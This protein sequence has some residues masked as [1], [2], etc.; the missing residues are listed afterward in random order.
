MSTACSARIDVEQRG[1][2]EVVRASVRNFN[3]DEEL[4][5]LA[6]AVTDLATS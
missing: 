2:D 4:D 5:A 3:T 1:L 6:V